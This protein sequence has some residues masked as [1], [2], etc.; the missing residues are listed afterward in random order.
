LRRFS[1]YIRVLYY[2]EDFINLF[3]VFG[4]L[5]AK[6]SFDRGGR[7]STTYWETIGVYFRLRAIKVLYYKIAISS[8]IRSNLLTSKLL[9]LLGL[10]AEKGII[11]RRTR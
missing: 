6:D 2:V 8:S 11:R 3:S 9:L 4:N 5:L 10:E 1:N 7:Y